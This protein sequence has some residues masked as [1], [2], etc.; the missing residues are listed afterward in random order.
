MGEVSRLG[1]LGRWMV[2]DNVGGGQNG[3]TPITTMGVIVLA[4]V[5]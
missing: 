1:L 4:A 3:Y 5:D 2:V